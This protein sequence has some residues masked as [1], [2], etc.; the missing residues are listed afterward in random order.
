MSFFLFLLLAQPDAASLIAKVDENYK[1]LKSFHIETEYQVR[2][3]NEISTT[4]SRRWSSLIM[5]SPTKLR[6]YGVEPYGSYQVISDGQTLWRVANHLRLYMTSPL[7]GAVL[8]ARDGG[9]EGSEAINQLRMV[10]RSLSSRSKR[11]TSAEYLPDETILDSGNP[12]EC[13]V[14]RAN[15]ELYPFQMKTERTFWIDPQRL[16]VLRESA[17][18]EGT[19]GPMRP[20]QMN[21]TSQSYAYR[22]LHLGSL[23]AE[24]SFKFD[25]P[26]NFFQVDKLDVE[27]SLNYSLDMVGKP[28]PEL[29]AITSE[30]R[31][32][33]LS[34]YKGKVVLLDF[35]ATWCAPCVAQ[36]P[37]IAKLYEK[38]KDQDMVLLG[39]NDDEAIDTARDFLNRNGYKWTNLFRA[40]TG[41]TR[42]NFKVSAIPTLILIDREGK[43]QAYEVGSG[44]ETEEK[45]RA[46]LIKQGLKLD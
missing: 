45:I 34:E 28:A 42:G 27:T 2:S 25:P 16:L 21:Y 38:T 35:W 12:V 24:Q 31:Q 20:Y 22:H 13:K 41:S 8:E 4:L 15:Y 1:N 19:I 36:M 11:L 18:Y 39:I 46:A 29:S 32:T 14:V 26:A 5:E 23:P 40:N 6:F 10:S 44:P 30:G 37:S 33:S 43:V 7:K 9:R 3:D 17:K